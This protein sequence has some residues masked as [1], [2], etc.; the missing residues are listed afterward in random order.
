[1]F[2]PR[3]LP[4]LIGVGVGEV[5]PVGVDVHLGDLLLGTGEVLR[6]VAGEVRVRRR[7]RR[8]PR[9][10]RPAAVCAAG[11]ETQPTGHHWGRARL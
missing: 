10:G 3:Y 4:S 1:M 9:G 11:R 7:G 8:G 2:L 6:L 5:F